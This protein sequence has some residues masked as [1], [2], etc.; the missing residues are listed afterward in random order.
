M[1]ASK[2]KWVRLGD[3]IREV[4]ERNYQGMHY[5]FFGL[6]KDKEFMPTVAD[7]T[8]LDNTKYKMVREGTFVFSGMQTGRDGCIRLGF[9]DKGAIILISP[10]YTT[11][12]IVDRSP[13]LPEYLFMQFNRDE[14]DRYGAFLS[15]GSIRSNLDWER[16]CDIRFPLPPLEVQQE[17]VDS[18]NG[19]KRLAEDNEALIAPLT[20]ACEAL[21]ADCKRKYPLVPLGNYIE[22]YKALNLNNQI[23]VVK[24]VS[25]TKELKDTNAKV[26]KSNLSGYKVVPPGHVTYVQTTKNEKC[27]ACAVNNFEYPIVVTSVNRVFRVTDERLD[28]D[29]LFLLLSQKGFDRYAIY[30]SWGSARETFDW[31]ELCRVEIPLPPLEV[32]KS[33]A[34]LYR[35]IEEARAIAR[36]A[37]EQLQTLAPALIRK[38]IEA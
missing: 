35:C 27:F 13:I 11:F 22:E 37:T 2:T 20:D 32:Q 31:E 18:Y 9:Q 16:F 10:A 6:N 8:N 5:P 26:D 19:V 33:I 15:D 25:V 17:V 4:D 30:H 1:T 34:R 29:Y 23:R 12:R 7:T 36:E 14:M 28:T 21:V 38:A 24:S 3:Y